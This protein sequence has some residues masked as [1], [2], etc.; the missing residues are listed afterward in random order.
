M[1]EKKARIELDLEGNKV[2]VRGKL[3]EGDKHWGMRSN[4]RFWKELS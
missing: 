3:N 1:I 4:K 2:L